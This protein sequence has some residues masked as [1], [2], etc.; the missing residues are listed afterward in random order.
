[1]IFQSTAHLLSRHRI[2]ALAATVTLGTM[3]AIL[4]SLP[5]GA[6]TTA[7]AHPVHHTL[8]L[9]ARFG[10]VREG[11]VPARV[12]PTSSGRPGIDT[13]IHLAAGE[14]AVLTATGTA[15]CRSAATGPCVHLGPDGDGL[16][17]G[18]TPAF[19]DPSA[20]AYSLVGEVGSGPLTFIGVGATT[21]QGPGELRLGYNDRLGNYADNHGGFKVTILR[22]T[23]LEVL[24]TT[25]PSAGMPGADTG[26]NLR[27]GQVAVVTATGTASCHAEDPTSSCGDIDAN[28]KG[29]ATSTGSPFFDPSAPAYSLVGE[30]GSG[31]LTF[32]GAGPTAVRGPGELRLGYNDMLGSYADN[33]GAFTV[34]IVTCPVGHHGGPMRSLMRPWR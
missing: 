13:R 26:I 17:T 34:T 21:V 7:P 28:G 10:H 20:P 12:P 31:P 22:A 25:A 8:A 19:F 2:G 14:V 15:S 5:A 9:H 29:P 33:G 24:A 32:I 23:R 11:F 4:G 18:G 1:V 3:G 30:V 6:A 16:A 27:R